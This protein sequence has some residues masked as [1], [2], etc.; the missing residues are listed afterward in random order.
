MPEIDIHGSGSDNGGQPQGR[1]TA[2][3]EA[4]LQRAADA[5][6]EREWRTTLRDAYRENANR[7]QIAGRT[8]RDAYRADADRTQQGR[9]VRGAD[10]RVRQEAYAEDRERDRIQR[11]AAKS[12]QGWYKD[13]REENTWRTRGLRFEQKSERDAHRAQETQY[14][15]DLRDAYREDAD[16]TRVRKVR[17]AQETAQRVALARQNP[18]FW[19]ADDIR[20]VGM[21]GQRAVRDR[22]YR[23]VGYAD[24]ELGKLS[25]SIAR[26]L[27][28]RP[29]DEHLLAQQTAVGEARARMEAS[30]GDDYT[31]GGGIMATIGRL[32]AGPVAKAIEIAIGAAET[33]IESPRI[34]S[35]T[36]NRFLSAARPYRDL[37]MGA[38][39]Y[40]RAGGFAGQGLEDT[41]FNPTKMQPWMTRR[42]L[43]QESAMRLLG[44]YGVSP[45][46]SGEAR[47][48]LSAIGD[49][50]FMPGLGGLGMD[51]YAKM[52]GSA[53]NMGAQGAGFRFGSNGA[54]AG[55]PAFFR[56]WQRTMTAAVSAGLDR[57]Q[58]SNS[59]EGLMSNVVRAGGANADL[60]RTSDFWWR[61]AANGAP[62]FRTG[63]G[64]LQADA[65]MN[66]A[67]SS[68]GYGGGNAQNF[69]IANYFTRHKQKSI[70]D[71]AGTL[72]VDFKSLNPAQQAQMGDAFKAY[73]NGDW[74]NFNE[75]IK[76][77]ETSNKQFWQSVTSDGGMGSGYTGAL[78]R[79]RLSGAG[80]E[81]QYQYDQGGVGARPTAKG[82]PGSGW[83][84]SLY[85]LIIDRAKAH[86]IPPAIA[87]G[88]V[89][90]ED[91][92]GDPTIKGPGTSI[93][94]TQIERAARQ[95]EGL[96]DADATDPRKNLD[97]GFDYL[98]K[99]YK[100]AG[101][102]DGALTHFHMGDGGDDGGNYARSVMRKAQDFGNIPDDMNK[103]QTLGGQLQTDASKQSQNYVAAMAEAGPTLVKF[104]GNVTLGTQAV[105]RFMA[106]LLRAATDLDHTVGRPAKQPWDP[107]A[108]KTRQ[109]L[110][111]RA[112]DPRFLMTHG[113]GPV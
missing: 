97:A 7:D 89:A 3:Q 45:R 108:P 85:S 39:D 81:A 38:L 44:E 75:L 60:T 9:T 42:G 53:Q 61:M 111:G 92:S 54:A 14:R 27:M 23:E 109:L 24:R 107:G 69:M 43:T 37:H 10:M 40:G 58:V 4:A 5:R 101:T 110:P 56:D 48:L 82:M 68:S 74:L 84:D 35:D 1:L 65:G 64:T 87:L 95:D 57:S 13:A 93:G 18:E 30:K 46:S 28:F 34:I 50:Q 16:R 105:E 80:T 20:R 36:Y 112:N 113:R 33:V 94:L 8:R 63:E 99:R 11:A 104:V 71:L 32:A 96:S 106:S 31:A 62:Q 52:L 26:K 12:A 67:I 41:L 29:G 98:A 76:P 49:A 102:W 17:D 19:K 79:G 90:Q 2:A 73:Q 59:I 83:S 25:D 15:T 103:Q 91:A 21:L 55:A 70:G 100:R 88:L 72:G 51:A 22:D 47:S 66:A 77:W 78:I 6:A 86:G